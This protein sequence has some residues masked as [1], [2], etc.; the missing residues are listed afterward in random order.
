M[1]TGTEG[2]D[3]RTAVTLARCQRE[4]RCNN[5]GEDKEYVTE[6]DC[7]TRLEP[8]TERELEAGGCPRSIPSTPL[9]ACMEAIRKESCD[10]PRELASIK[11]CSA[12]K[13]CSK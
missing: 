2:D 5:V 3:S 6:E 1:I 12:A 7:I 13:L 8:N 9:G 10:G 4:T 11:E